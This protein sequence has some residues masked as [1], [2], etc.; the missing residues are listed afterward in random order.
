MP[1]WIF[2]ILLLNGIVS[3]IYG[4]AGS[5]ETNTLWG[6]LAVNFVYFLGLTQT[7]VVFS[8]LM[9][10]SKSGW[11]RYFSR[12]GEIL[13]LA[14]IPVA[15]VVFLVIYFGGT[16]HLFF[17]AQPAGP[18]SHAISPWLGRP[19]FLWRN[20]GTMALFYIVSYLYF[21]CGRLEEKG[22]ATLYNVSERRSVWAAFVLITYILTNTNVAWDFGMMLI[23]HWESA[24]FPAYYWA[25]NLLANTAFLVV[26]SLI[27]ITKRMELDKKYLDSISKV[28]IGFVLLWTYMFWSQFVVIWYGNQPGLVGPFFKRM[29]GNYLPHAV[30]MMLAVFI[31]P[32]LALLFR[33]IKFC[34]AS[35]ATVGGII[36]IGMWLNRYLMIV[37]E[38]S[39]G[40]EFVL[41][42][43]TGISMAI[44]G[45]SSVI[46]SVAL[47]LKLFP[48]VTVTTVTDEAGNGHG[49]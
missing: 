23:P 8:A 36:L 16:D 4:V 2:W 6:M 13:T 5:A 9:K 3:F 46:V 35:L 38:Y 11:G 30:V 7:G 10:L 47:F 32:F 1:Y 41:G 42:T 37:P 26:L 22:E 21:R 29:T 33:R 45:L 15:F 19:Q 24:I 40:S 39:D 28:M 17:W 34:A 25:G 49:H 43:W 27:F 14:F 18:H 48:G 31:V 12:L 44:G 20:V